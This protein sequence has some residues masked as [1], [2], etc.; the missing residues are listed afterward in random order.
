MLPLQVGVAFAES[1]TQASSLGAAE[2]VAAIIA[3]DDDLLGALPPPQ[4]DH[5]LSTMD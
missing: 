5:M 1:S 2:P 4:V 3:D